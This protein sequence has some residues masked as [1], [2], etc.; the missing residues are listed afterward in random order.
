M[1]DRFYKLAD[2]ITRMPAISTPI[3]SGTYENGFWWLKFSININHP[4][5]W[6]IVQELSYVVNYLSISERL[7]TVFYPVSG[8]PSVKQGPAE[9]LE[10]IIEST[11]ADFSPSELAEWLENR[12][13]NPVDDLRAWF[14][15]KKT[16]AQL[17]EFS[18]EAE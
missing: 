10:W 13:P 17:K 1:Q 12:L 15:D 6:H 11:S 14:V 4:L 18:E 8:P 16:N 9:T 5:A 2:F 7:S 3:A